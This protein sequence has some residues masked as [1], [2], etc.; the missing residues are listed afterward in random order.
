MRSSAFVDLPPQFLLGHEMSTSH[1]GHTAEIF[2]Q[3]SKT[4]MVCKAISRERLSGS[5][6]RYFLSVVDHIQTLRS[7]DIIAY[8]HVFETKKYIYLLR[9]YIQA[10][11]LVEYNEKDTDTVLANWSAIAKIVL[12]LHDHHICPIFLKP[13]NIF[14]V[15]GNKVVLTD[16][17]PPS[18]N[19]DVMVHSPACFDIGFLAPEFF[20]KSETG[21]ASDLW[22]LGVLLIVMLTKKLPWECKNVFTMVEQIQSGKPNYP[23]NLPT[24]IE[25]ILLHCLQLDPSHRYGVLP[26][27]RDE[28]SR[29]SFCRISSDSS[30]IPARSA[31]TLDSTHVKE[32]PTSG[33]NELDSHRLGVFM[34]HNRIPVEAR[35]DLASSSPLL[36]LRKRNVRPVL[37]RPAILY[38][39]PPLLC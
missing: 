19:L 29:S 31:Q 11:S 6:A 8:S 33:K 13:S 15:K 23:Q 27:I 30:L 2:D 37:V 7:P 34:R 4:A 18:I 9:P 21:P 3:E 38:N 12:H 5:A 39:N 1:I 22:G 24:K 20:S 36:P 14:V 26:M 32:R 16:I 10:P 28:S 35:Q 25:T 17:Y